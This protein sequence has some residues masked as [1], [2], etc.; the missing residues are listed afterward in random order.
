MLNKNPKGWVSAVE[1]VIIK[2]SVR[3]RDRFRGSPSVRRRQAAEGRRRGDLK[4][5]AEL[6]ETS[7]RKLRTAGGELEQACQLFL[8][9]IADCCPEP[10]Q[11]TPEFSRST[12]HHVVCPEVSDAVLTCA[13]QQQL[14]MDGKKK[15]KEIVKWFYRILYPQIKVQSSWLEI[16]KLS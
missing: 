4:P 5:R 15:N 3:L 2:Y 6:R 12:A 14:W 9:E 10:V 16:N 7:R 1:P 11:H 13:T 8:C